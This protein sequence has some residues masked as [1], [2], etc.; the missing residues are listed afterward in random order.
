MS[1]PFPP[2]EIIKN[3]RFSNGEFILVG[4]VTKEQR[5]I[6]EAFKRS[7]EKEHRSRCEED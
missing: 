2:K 5:R 6:F 7:F 4:E 1:M 3:V